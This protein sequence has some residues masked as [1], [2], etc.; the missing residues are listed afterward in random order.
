MD[1]K[2]AL[3]I[4]ELTEYASSEEI[5][6][7]ISV[8]YKKFK[9]VKT[10][11]RGYTI[12]DVEQAYNTIR[13]ITYTDEEEEK[14]KKYRR[15]HPNPIFKFL[16]VDEKKAGDFI[17]YYKW[18]GLIILLLIVFVTLT[19]YSIV[20]R[21]EPNLK[22]LITGNTYIDDPKILEEKI[23]LETKGLINAQVQSIYLPE[24]I[25]SQIDL[26]MQTKITVELAAGNNDI[27]IVD[28]FNFLQLAKQG[29]FKPVKSLLEDISALGINN[30]GKDIFFVSV[31]S[32]D[33]L[34]NGEVIYGIDISD[35]NLLRDAGVKGEI[36]VLAFGNT[37]E[38]SKN[39]II[40]TKKLL[41]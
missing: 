16:K 30:E 18:H 9:Q 35:N 41:E 8:F 10:D 22:I 3:E 23:S 2:E 6:N 37:V 32:E 26:A 12:F 17:Y 21:V 25:D 19:I 27:F 39:T 13:G 4:L 14:K 36:L 29:A 40:F 11:S 7:R 34:K 5:E 15:E 20:N 38:N 33:G 1:R 28:E 24:E 31:K